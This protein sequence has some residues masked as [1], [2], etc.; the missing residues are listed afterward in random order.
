MKHISIAALLLIAASQTLAQQPYMEKIDVNVVNVDVT[1]TSH[2]KP[3]RGLT[4]DDFIILEDG[5]PQPVT[6]FYA[7]EGTSAVVRADAPSGAAAAPAVNAVS[8]ERFRR[9]VLVVVDNINTSKITRNRALAKLESFIDERFASGQYDWSI[10]VAGSQLHVLLPV[11]SDK[12]TLHTAIEMIRKEATWQQYRD[13]MSAREEAAAHGAKDARDVATVPAEFSSSNPSS[14]FATFEGH[15]VNPNVAI[16]SIMAERESE[17]MS[18]GSIRALRDALR[19][20]STAPGRKLILLLTSGM[21]PAA[22]AH[23]ENLQGSATANA[24]E[25]GSQSAKAAVLLRDMLIHEANASNVSVYIVNPDGLDPESPL[26]NSSMF[27]LAHETGGTLMNPN[28]PELALQRFEE[29]SGS[30]YSLGYAAHHADDAKYHDIKVRLRNGLKYDLQYRRG[31]ANLSSD[32]QLV[33]TLLTPFAAAMQSSAIPL[34]VEVG[35][36]KSQAGRTLVPVN[37]TVPLKRF[38]FVPG[39]KDWTA[40]IDFYVSV[41]DANGKNLGLQRFVTTAHAAGDQ[42]DSA[43]ELTQAATLQLKP[44]R[45][46]TVVVAVRDQVTD[47]FGIS[48]QRVNF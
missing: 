18:G 31:Y 37:T 16:N 44:G 28:R 25:M 39:S 22:D 5:K 27:W 30:F 40:K 6:N 43:G 8:D 35:A 14:W 42:S 7:V 47:T 38:Q 32:V 29:M 33:R 1:V 13:A 9:R 4:K 17:M 10:A 24:L 48:T 19:A 11:T 2:G 26:P 45:P 15:D 46:A 20:F 23:L 36:A 3:V 21:L 41:F 34:K 12:E